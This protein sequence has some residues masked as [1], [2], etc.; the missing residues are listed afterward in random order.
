MA[1]SRNT[2]VVT[3]NTDG[4]DKGKSYLITELSCYDAEKWANQLLFG[5]MNAGV[6]VPKNIF[7]MGLAGIAAL[8]ISMLGKLPFERAE[9]LLEKMWTCV[10][11]VP[12]PRNGIPRPGGL[13]DGDVEEV[14]TMIHLRAQILDL[15]TGFFSIVAQL[16]LA[17]SNDATPENNPSSA[18]TFPT[19]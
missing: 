12:D 17:P 2:R 9:P 14:R 15:H 16:K 3:I 5:L 11:Y 4:R 19:Q 18:P 1:S 13:Q 8:G 10:Q 6:D 7:D